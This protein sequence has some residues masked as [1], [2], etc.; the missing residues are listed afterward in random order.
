[1]NFFYDKILD[2]NIKHFSENQLASVI[3]IELSEIQT[4]KVTPQLI[5]YLSL[6]SYYLIVIFL[7]WLFAVVILAYTCIHDNKLIVMMKI[8]HIKY[9]KKQVT[10]NTFVN[11]L[12]LNK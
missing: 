3:K 8:I 1:M 4:R 2:D 7:T 12:K 5:F 10:V 11:F 9:K 6:K